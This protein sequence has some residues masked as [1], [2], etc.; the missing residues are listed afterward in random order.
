MDK[1]ELRKSILS[2]R[3]S[4]NKELLN[5]KSFVI[6][7]KIIEKI[8]SDKYDI[9]LS[10]ADFKGEVKTNLINE[11]VLKNG[12][13]L[14]LPRVIDTLNSKMEFCLVSSLNNLNEGSFGIL[15]PSGRENIFDYESLKNPKILMIVPGVCFDIKLHRIGYGKGF[16][17]N[18]LKD[19]PTI[20]KSALALDLQIVDNIMSETHDIR[21]DEIV[22]ETN[23]YK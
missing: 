12:L 23:I 8:I 20:Y 3:G 17:D 1:N 18:Y 13:K 21:M 22:T 11:Y 5:D 10:Y 4:L 15:E 16:Y 2:K 14:F 6:E 19:K 9:I 7:N